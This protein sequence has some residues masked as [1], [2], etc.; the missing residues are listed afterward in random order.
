MG[1]YSKALSCG[2][3]AIEI[4]RDSLPSNHPCFAESYNNIGLLYE[5]MGEYAKAR[6]FFENAVNIGQQSLPS[7]HPDLKNWRN[8]LEDIKKKL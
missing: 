6:S 7:N 2:Q 1:E 8:N 5:N 4:F 3:K